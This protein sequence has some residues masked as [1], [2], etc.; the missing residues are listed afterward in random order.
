MS[1]TR[2]LL[3]ITTLVH[4]LNMCADVSRVP[5][6]T[7]TETPELNNALSMMPIVADN[8]VTETV[9]VVIEEI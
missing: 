6:I 8:V 3:D 1:M 4:V 2:T 5:A 7:G 9:E